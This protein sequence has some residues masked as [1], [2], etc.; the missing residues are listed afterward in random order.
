VGIAAVIAYL[1]ERLAAAYLFQKEVLDK[2]R[3]LQQFQESVITNANVWISVLAPDGMTITV[4]ND[5]AE[6]ISGYKRGDVRGKKTVWRD[7]YPDKTYRQKVTREIKR[8]IGRD[9]YLE[10]FETEIR[11]ADGTQKTIVWNTRGIRDAAGTIQ[12][13]IAIG[14]D[15]TEQK[16][17]EEE[18]RLLNATLEQRVRDRTQEL[19][20]ATE[21]IRASLDEKV[22][23]LRE[24]HHRV[25]NNLQIIISLLNLQSRYIEDEKT[26]QVIHESQNRIRAMALVHEKLYQSTD[27]GKIDLE[28]YIRL[29]GDS[30]FQFYGMKGKGIFLNTQIQDVKVDINTAIPVGLIVNELFSN[31]LKHAFPDGRK[32]DISLAIH[33][34]D[35]ILTIVFKDNGVG[36]PQ[37]FDW[38]NAKSLGLRLVISLVEQLQGTIEL[39]QTTGTT[40]TIVVKEKE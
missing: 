8:V 33:R 24:I 31:S 6:T 32:G 12:S 20:Q 35:H 5:A 7:L 22:I 34:Q 15:I 30:L 2:I 40:F 11:C 17:A 27:I 25:K 19:E 16:R 9:T 37:D 13:Y 18:I 4:W 3:N 26:R 14:R 10:N 28:N 36:I 29:L 39:D 21:T 1:S 38:R 23:L